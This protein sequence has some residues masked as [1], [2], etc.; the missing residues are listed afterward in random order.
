M[1]HGQVR[2][3]CPKCRANNFPGVPHCWQ[4]GASLPPPES[5]AQP[6]QRPVSPAG[7]RALDP[8]LPTIESGVTPSPPRPLTP[9]PTEPRRIPWLW[10]RVTA[11]SICVLWGLFIA[12]YYVRM[13]NQA[14]TIDRQ[15]DAIIEQ[16]E[17]YMRDL[18]KALHNPAAVS[19]PSAL[20][21]NSQEAQA[22]R[23]L[24]RLNKK[25]DG[26]APPPVSPDGR[27]HLETGGSISAQEW[28][29]AKESLRGLH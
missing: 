24:E 16:N 15:K 6:V 5:V 8:R 2:I 17:R 1:N 12:A 7:R 10:L 3:P 26:T 22:R 19:D 29:R 25:L 13:H 28:E 27:V 23:E 4:C 20:D 14:T 18:D 21:P 9:S 11:V